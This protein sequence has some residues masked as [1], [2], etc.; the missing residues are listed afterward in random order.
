[1]ANTWESS[2]KPLYEIT[3]L[4]CAEPMGEDDIN[5]F[6]L[7]PCEDEDSIHPSES[8]TID[9]FFCGDCAKIINPTFRERAEWDSPITQEQIDHVAELPE[10]K[11]R[12]A[13]NRLKGAW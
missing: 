9:H 12:L 7:L 6:S 5:S 13:I 4:T 10:V 1:M 8:G 2:V 3:C 11:K